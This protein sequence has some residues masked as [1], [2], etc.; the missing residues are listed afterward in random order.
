LENEARR[1][2]MIRGGEI[3]YVV[4]GLPH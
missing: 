1:T 3:P 4:R 2:G